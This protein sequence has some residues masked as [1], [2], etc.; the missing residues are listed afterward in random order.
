M[1]EL[2]NLEQKLVNKILRRL[3]LYL[4]YP[5]VSHRERITQI[6]NSQPQSYVDLISQISRLRSH[7]FLAKIQ[8]NALEPLRSLKPPFTQEQQQQL[9]EIFKA[10]NW[11]GRNLLELVLRPIVS[12]ARNKNRERSYVNKLQHNISQLNHVKTLYAYIPDADKTQILLPC[13]TP[14]VHMVAIQSH[15]NGKI[16]YNDR[17]IIEQFSLLPE[18]DKQDFLLSSDEQRNNTLMRALSYKGHIHLNFIVFL[19]K[20][21]RD[22]LNEEQFQKL[23]QQSN[24]DGN[25]AFTLLLL[26]TRWFEYP[27]PKFLTNLELLLP[28]DLLPLA[29]K[30]IEHY[31]TVKESPLTQTAAIHT[32]TAPQSSTSYSSSFFQAP[33]QSPEN[34]RVDLPML[35]DLIDQQ[36]KQN[37]QPSSSTTDHRSLDSDVLSQ[38]RELLTKGDFD[39]LVE[40]CDRLQRQYPNNSLLAELKEFAHN[41]NFY[42]FSTAFD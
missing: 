5:N 16:T 20:Q 35:I 13:I 40:R 12:V 18:R 4:M 1:R 41:E 37:Q 17:W 25:T 3:K 22:C 10:K 30:Q 36:M 7:G 14:R 11:L 42:Q 34:E 2:N 32:G 9:G 27:S 21:A 23:W 24:V 15:L 26:K 31:K 39:T 29:I 28:D 38:L 19:G 33:Q 8:Q 6:C